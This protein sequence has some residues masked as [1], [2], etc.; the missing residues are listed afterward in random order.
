VG[1]GLRARGRGGGDGV[2]EGCGGGGFGGG[3]YDWLAGRDEAEEWLL[4]GHL[5]L[6]IACDPRED[7]YRSSAVG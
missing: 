4:L 6:L 5:F 2:E 1:E 7:A 3:G